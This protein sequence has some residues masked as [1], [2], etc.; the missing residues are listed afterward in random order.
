MH[1]ALPQ[2]RTCISGSRIDDDLDPH[3]TLRS[4]IDSTAGRTRCK[5]R[6]PKE[7]RVYVRRDA[8]SYNPSYT[9]EISAARAVPAALPGSPK[10]RACSGKGGL[11]AESVRWKLGRKCRIAR[12]IV[13]MLFRL[14]QQFFE[15]QHM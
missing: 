6:Y 8:C 5:Q 7:K 11:S 14:M 13:H 15:V 3:C 10:R 2:A 1:D 9:G 12:D 4:G